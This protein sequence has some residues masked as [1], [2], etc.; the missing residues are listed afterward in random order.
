MVKARLKKDEFDHA[1]QTTSE[2]EVLCGQ[3]RVGDQM[4]C[5]HIDTIYNQAMPVLLEV[6]ICF[7]P[8]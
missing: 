1:V 3:T 8:Y 5:G 7:F 4:D 6:R 2:G